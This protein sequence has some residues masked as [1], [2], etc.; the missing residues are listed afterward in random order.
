MEEKMKLNFKEE[1]LR[2]ELNRHAHGSEKLQSEFEDCKR[3]SDK[4]RFELE[5]TK[6]ELALWKRKSEEIEGRLN[7]AEK[8]GTEAEQITEHFKQKGKEGIELVI[9]EKENL[10]QERDVITQKVETAYREVHGYKEQNVHLL[11]TIESNSE[12][13]NMINL[14]VVEKDKLLKDLQIENNGLIDRTSTYE[15]EIKVMKERQMHVDND[16]KQMEQMLCGLTEENQDMKAK[17]AEIDAL[18]SCIEE[19]R[20][21]HRMETKKLK[22]EIED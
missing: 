11:K 17:Q 6:G 18:Q 7:L 4:T 15:Y 12:Y 20:T 16:K 8:K 21:H 3:E 5:K 1:T 19:E 10:R 13:Y 14:T 22:A 9:R 2:D